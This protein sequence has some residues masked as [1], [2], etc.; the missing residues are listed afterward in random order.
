MKVNMKPQPKRDGWW[1]LDYRPYGSKGKRVREIVEGYAAAL[2]LKASLEGKPANTLHPT[3]NDISGDYLAWCRENLK[4]NSWKE[5]RNRFN[6]F[7]FPSLGHL[8]V[9]DLTQPIL[10]G[11]LRGKTKSTKRNDYTKILGLVAWMVKRNYAR[12][13]DWQPERPAYRPRLKRLPD[14]LE[15]VLR[16]IACLRAEWVQ[17]ACLMMLLTG[18]RWCEVSVLRWED[19]RGGRILLQSTKTDDPQTIAIPAPCLPWF[20][21]HRKPSG[22]VFSQ[23]NRNRPPARIQKQLDQAAKVAGVRM[24]PH[25]FRHMSATVLYDER[26]DIYAVQHHLRHS[27]VSTTEIYTRYSAIRRQRSVDTLTR[28]FGLEKMESVETVEDYN[29]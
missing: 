29:I 14:E 25:M 5:Y 13:L 9:K 24:T 8:R 26:E 17:T 16:V 18:A 20:E 19:L 27:K 15:D 23:G 1:I 11:Y 22:Y 28:A 2:T 6:N 12:P 4:A 21:A 3:L 10:D 7:I